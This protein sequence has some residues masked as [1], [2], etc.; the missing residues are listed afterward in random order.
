MYIHL[1][2]LEGGLEGSSS[3]APVSVAGC[4]EAIILNNT[5]MVFITLGFLM[6]L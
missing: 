6:N 4:P 5:G 1:A 3:A 2:P